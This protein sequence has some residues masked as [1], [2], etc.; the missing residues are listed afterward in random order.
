MTRILIADDSQPVRCGLRTLL[1]LNSDWQVCGEAVDGADTDVTGNAIPNQTTTFTTGT[2]PDVLSPVIVWTNPLETNSSQPPTN[3]PT[4]AIL[5]VE[6]NEPL[7]PG[8]INSSSFVVHDSQSQTVAGAYSLSADGLTATFVPSA[9]FAANQQYSVS[10]VNGAITD[11][12]G[13]RL[14]T[15]IT[16]VFG[17]FSFTTSATSNTSAP[18]VAVVSPDYVG[19]VPNHGLIPALDRAC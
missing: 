13:N 3:I 9:P 2:G 1:G 17:S 11:L 10:A 7:D 19:S 4:N 18:Q 12:A 6:A 8:T 5:Q 16:G 15:S 14:S